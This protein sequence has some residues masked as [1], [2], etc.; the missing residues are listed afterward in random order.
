M[1]NTPD[2]VG[3]DGGV[4]QRVP[5]LTRVIQ[6]SDLEAARRHLSL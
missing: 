4:E 5:R 2:N 6:E 1:E 3:N